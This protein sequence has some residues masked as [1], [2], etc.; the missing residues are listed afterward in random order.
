MRAKQLQ[1][2]VKDLQEGKEYSFRVKAFNESAEGPPSE[3]SVVAKDEIGM[4]LI[5]II[6]IEKT[7]MLF[8]CQTTL[9]VLFAVLI[10]T[11]LFCSSPRL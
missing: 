6:T 9:L 3:L 11:Y 7:Q 8:Y 10:F 1:Y 4:C 5:I 2:T